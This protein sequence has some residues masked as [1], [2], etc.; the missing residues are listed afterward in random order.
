[1]ERALYSDSKT[2]DCCSGYTIDSVR[3][4][5]KGHQDP[6]LMGHHKEKLNK[7]CLRGPLGIT[8][9]ICFFSLS[10]APVTCSPIFIRTQPG[11]VRHNAQWLSSV[12]L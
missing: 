10:E 2:E 1:M 7:G 3:P 4:H 11:S 12:A 8:T 6:L 5:E 9:V